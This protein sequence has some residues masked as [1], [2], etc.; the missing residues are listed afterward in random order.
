MPRTIS[1]SQRVIVTSMMFFL[2]KHFSTFDLLMSRYATS[3]SPMISTRLPTTE[4]VIVIEARRVDKSFKSPAGEL[5]K[6]ISEGTMM[7]NIA[8]VCKTMALPIIM[9]CL[10][11]LCLSLATIAKQRIVRMMTWSIRFKSERNGA[12][13]LKMPILPRS[14][15]S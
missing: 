4:C 1:V 6:L 5:S 3:H 11:K 2:L 8:N 15:A 10:T 7:A 12:P 9:A 13:G 14:P